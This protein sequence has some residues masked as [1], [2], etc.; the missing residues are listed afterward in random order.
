MD[1]FED[2][3]K[4][5]EFWNQ[6]FE[7]N[8]DY[9]VE[10]KFIEDDNFNN[11]LKKYINENSEVL[12]FGCGSGWALPEIYFTSK[13]KYGLGVDQS[14]NG[15]K[16]AIKT[17][18]ISLPNADIAYTCAPINKIEKQFDFIF[19]CNTLDV[20]PDEVVLE[21]IDDLKQRTKDGGYVLVCLNPIFTH[22]QM[23]NTIKAELKDDHYYYINGVFR[24]NVKSVEEWV[25]L[26]K[27]NFNVLDY[28]EFFLTK[29]DKYLRRYYLLQK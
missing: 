26:F 14:E 12:D 9:K 28:G 27:K 21:M 11:I 22:D 20:V 23:V 3:K 4:S 18:E 24:C 7:G 6:V 15:I 17:A 10:G 16:A 8:E 25:A 13:F 19:T 2:Y 29:N 1:R 5:Q